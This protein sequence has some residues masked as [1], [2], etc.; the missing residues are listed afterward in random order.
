MQIS[1]WVCGGKGGKGGSGKGGKG[2]GGDKG[3]GGAAV[4]AAGARRVV[5]ACV[6]ACAH[7]APL[8]PQLPAAT[9]HRA[10]KMRESNT[11][12]QR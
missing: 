12:Q 10:S 5:R 1:Q 7:R 4:A 11:L 2:G 9:L 3:G 8:S 6:R